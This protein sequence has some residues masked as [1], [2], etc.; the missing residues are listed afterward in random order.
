[1]AENDDG[2]EDY[3]RSR[4]NYDNEGMIPQLGPTA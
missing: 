1:M 3:G 4:N 2:D